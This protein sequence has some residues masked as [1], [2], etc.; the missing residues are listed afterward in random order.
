MFR[1][2]FN[3]I[4]S[5]LSLPCDFLIS[6][7]V[8]ELL[9]QIAY[10]M[11]YSAVG[12]LDLHGGIGSAMHWIIRLVIMFVM[13]Y[14]TCI[15]MYVVRFIVLHWLAFLISLFLL[16]IYIILKLYADD[17]AASFLNKDIMEKNVKVRFLDLDK[18]YINSVGDQRKIAMSY[19]FN[20]TYKTRVGDLYKWCYKTFYPGECNFSDEYFLEHYCF[21]FDNHTILHP[22]LDMRLSKYIRIYHIKNLFIGLQS[23]KNG[24]A[25]GVIDNIGEIR[26]Y[27]KDHGAPHAHLYKGKFSNNKGVRINLVDLK[28]FDKDLSKYGE[29][30][31][32]KEKKIIESLLQDNRDSLLKFYF[33]VQKGENPRPILIQSDGVKVWIK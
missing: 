23:C 27:P 26:I 11:A 5:N 15:I 17:H 32:K 28:V 13:W 22:R 12:D 29:Y 3:I 21:C 30:F 1:I 18:L 33:E 20:Y 2:I 10:T 6:L 7:V 16:I 25:G 4:T 24:G 31:S 9:G 8:M 14:V 19:M